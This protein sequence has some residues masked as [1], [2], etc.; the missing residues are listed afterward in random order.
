M[1]PLPTAMA[2]VRGGC[3]P[4]NISNGGVFLRR[5]R[6]SN[7]GRGQFPSSGRGQSPYNSSGGPIFSGN[8]T[9]NNGRGAPLSVGSGRM[10]CQI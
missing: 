8:G 2:A 3:N 6:S 9:I 5:G 1:D 10:V 7:C 4:H